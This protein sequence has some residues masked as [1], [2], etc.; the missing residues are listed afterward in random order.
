MENISWNG[1]NDK[2]GGG[3]GAMMGIDVNKL[4]YATFTNVSVQFCN[5]T[6]LKLNGTWDCRFTGVDVRHCGNITT[7]SPGVHIPYNSA[8]GDRLT[9][10]M[11]WVGGVIERNRYGGVL[12]ESS[13]AIRFVGTKFHGRTLSDDTEARGYPAEDFLVRGEDVRTFIMDAC[14]F[15]LAGKYAVHLKQGA[16]SN[17]PYFAISDCTFGRTA[18]YRVGTVMTPTVTVALNTKVA[19]L[20][21]VTANLDNTPVKI[22]GATSKLAFEPPYP[23]INTNLYTYFKKPKARQA[24]KVYAFDDFMI[25]IVPN[26]YKYQC[27]VQGTASVST[28]VALPPIPGNTFVDGTVTWVC[29]DDDYYQLQDA[30]DVA[31]SGAAMYPVDAAWNIYIEDG[32]GIVNGNLFS[33]SEHSSLIAGGGD[34][35]VVS[36]V[37]EITGINSHNN[38]IVKVDNSSS[39][40]AQV[41]VANNYELYNDALYTTVQKVGVMGEVQPRME[42]KSDGKVRF[43]GGEYPT[44]VSISRTDLGEL[45]AGEL[46]KIQGYDERGDNNIW[47]ATTA[48]ALDVYAMPLT[49]N[50][51]RWKYKCTVAGTS[52]GTEPVWPQNPRTVVLDGTV[53]WTCENKHGLLVIPYTDNTGAVRTFYLWADSTGRLRIRTS[54]TGLPNAVND[55]DPVGTQT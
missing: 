39:S 48:Y 43:G 35:R 36:T 34:I 51:Y 4:T 6:G 2:Y 1:N 46:F 49:P 13:N 54:N 20:S 5:G 37:A 27:I 32:K 38:S 15:T 44:D 8:A 23:V 47:A 14:L 10:S 41:E 31:V 30:A 17:V 21:A 3:G 45:Q 24:G 22:M 7:S 29:R 52:A 42:L 19:V 50:G 26:G 33:W 11:L 25:P 55:G 16:E 18:N 28:D 9:Y 40:V 53:E 12:M